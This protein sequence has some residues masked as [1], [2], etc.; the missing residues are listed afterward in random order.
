MTARILLMALLATTLAMPAA[1]QQRDAAFVQP[2][3][4]GGK[5]DS[6]E[7]I[8]PS[9]KQAD[10]GPTIIG[11]TKRVTLYF[12]NYSGRDATISSISINADSNIRTEAVQN[13][14]TAL[15]KLKANDKC[16][17]IIEIT[18]NSPGKWTAEV[19]VVHD[20]A[21]RIS[22]ATITGDTAGDSSANGQQPGLSLVGAA[23]DQQIDFGDVAIGSHAARSVLLANDSASTLKIEKIELVAPDKGLA[24]TDQG[25]KEGDEVPAGASCPVTVLWQP[26]GSSDIST[27]LIIRH[28]GPVG[29]AV[30]PVRGKSGGGA[31]T[32]TASNDTKPQV[33]AASLPVSNTAIPA[34]PAADL[35]ARA[36]GE[37]VTMPKCAKDSVV[38]TG[39]GTM[40]LRGMAGEQAILSD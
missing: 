5:H 6:D 19:V 16:S 20:A 32:T 39:S 29:F 18:P 36:A 35:F 4:G 21:G 14:C 11:I 26:T 17:V 31:P 24:L 28:T 9:P 37:K 8:S 15:E 27:D 10:L 2:T 30:I 7:V 3:A 25:C 1:A 22:R 12:T 13:D 23:K 34:I 38:G 33:V 40:M